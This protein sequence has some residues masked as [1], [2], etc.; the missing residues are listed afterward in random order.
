M[1]IRNVLTGL[2]LGSLTATLPLGALAQGTS[3]TTIDRQFV[4]Q[5]MLSNAKAIKTADIERHSSNASV[6]MFART[7]VRDAGTAV[8]QLASVAN[9]E[10]IP[11]PRAAVVNVDRNAAAPPQGEPATVTHQN[12]AAH[13]AP[14]RSYMQNEITSLQSAIALYKYEGRNGSDQYV[15]A[16]ASRTLPVL[17]N[18]LTKA[19]QY[20]T[21][22]RITH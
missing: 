7:I 21:V 4:Q 12:I 2:A 20:M 17:Q 18:D 19:R 3:P 14:P 6:G 11:F 22:G 9:Q 8:A 1:K 13:P 16:Y 10:N 15:R 5:A